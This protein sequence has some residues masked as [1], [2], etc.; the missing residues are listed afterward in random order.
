MEWKLIDGN[1]VCEILGIS[2][3]TLY[4]W[5]GL[6]DNDFQSILNQMIQIDI[7]GE[8][9][10]DFPKPFKIGRIYKWSDKEINSWIQK[11]R[12]P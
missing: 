1:E 8:S 12:V 5:C 10:H 9:P 11:Q 2:K 4:R 3:S 7:K 6:S